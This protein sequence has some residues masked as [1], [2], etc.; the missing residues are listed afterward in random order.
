VPL[1]PGN[2]GRRSD[3]RGGQ[4]AGGGDGRGLDTTTFHSRYFAVE[5]PVGDSRYTERLYR[6]VVQN[7]CTERLCTERL[8]RTVVQNGC[9]ERLSRTVVCPC[10]QSP[11][12]TRE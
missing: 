4:A 5:T 3:E 12:T 8:Y 2:A 10:N 11:V 7:G 6:A 1:H 9:A